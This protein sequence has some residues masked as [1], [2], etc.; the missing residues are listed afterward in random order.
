MATTRD[1][2]NVE[3]ARANPGV[4]ANKSIAQVAGDSGEV[5]GKL[6]RKPAG[7]ALDFVKRFV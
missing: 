6:E 1:P 7:R 3:E 2:E 5:I 4:F